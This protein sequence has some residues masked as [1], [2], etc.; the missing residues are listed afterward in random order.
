M[1]T[2]LISGSGKRLG[3]GLAMRFAASGWDV[4]LHYR[5]SA[6]GAHSAA[7]EIK[8]QYGRRAEVF[9]ADLSVEEEAVG[10]VARA[11][12]AFGGLDVL[13]NNA[14][15]FPAAIPALEVKQ[16]QLDEYVRTNVYAALW[17]S[18]EFARRVGPE[19]EGRIV[20]LG[21]LGAEEVW[22][23]RL[24]YH[25]SKAALT[26]AM[27]ALALELAPAVS[28]NVVAPGLIVVPG[29]EGEGSMK[30]NDARFPMRRKGSV[31][32]LFD[33]IKFFAECSRYITGQVL[34]VDGGYRLARG[35]G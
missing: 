9:K 33:A 27:R 35:S 24:P 17:C 31:D 28:V 8:Q 26:H 22:R 25:M 5:S 13:V 23:G 3:R 12:D 18:Q 1:A 11:W 32:D 15:L 21:S 4:A 10:L 19:G 16:H 34:A 20:T 30:I 6:D 14:G 2:V 7:E 29:E